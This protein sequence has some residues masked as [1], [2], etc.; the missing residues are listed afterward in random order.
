MTK[1]NSEKVMIL[2]GDRG[3]NQ[4]SFFQF[5]EVTKVA[6]SMKKE[7]VIWLFEPFF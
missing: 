7:C 3:L 6:K 5:F 2:R 1:I 4:H